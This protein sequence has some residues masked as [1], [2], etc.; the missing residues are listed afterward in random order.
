MVEGLSDR[1]IAKRF[2]VSRTAV[3]HFRKNHKIR[4]KIYTGEIGEGIVANELQKA[5]FV[6]VN[7]N[8]RSK[9]HPYDLLVHGHIRIDVKTARLSSGR[10]Y[11]TLSQKPETGVVESSHYI[12]LN[13]RRLR[14]RFDKVC[15]FIILCGIQDDNYNLFVVPAEKIPERQ[16]TISIDPSGNGKW[17]DWHN[18]FDL[19]KEVIKIEKVLGIKGKGRLTE[20]R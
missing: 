11:F 9:I 8:K 2:E 17:W 7:M 20:Y 5:G 16:Q 6:V 19:I 13:N 3:V 18:R 10:W 1:E 15:D 14:K 4:T 12:K